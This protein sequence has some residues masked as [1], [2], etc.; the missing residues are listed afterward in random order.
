MAVRSYQLVLAAGAMRLSD[1]YGDGVGVVNPKNDIP[2]RQ[3]I[4]QA[5]G[6]AAFVGFTNAV[7]SSVFGI[8]IDNTFTGP[9]V[10]LGPFEAGP[11]KLSDLWV[12]GAGATISVLGVPF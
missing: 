5:A 2:Y 8:K 11:I 7:T 1:V 12:A 4:L 3:V 10:S 6:A 9:G